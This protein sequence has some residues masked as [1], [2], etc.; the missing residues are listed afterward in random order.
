[1]ATPDLTPAFLAVSRAKLL[2]EYLPRLRA[3]IEPLTDE[4]VWWRPNDASNSIGNLLLHL[5]GNVRQWLVVSFNRQADT[6]QRPAEFAQRDRIP[7]RAL[8]DRL[9]ATLDEAAATLS[10]LTAD[11]LAAAMQIQGYSTTGLTAVYHVVE[12]FGLHYGQIVYIAK[13]LQARDLGFYKELNATGR[14]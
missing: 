5:N 10:R 1:M 12:H 14:A 2:D 3:T 8:L 6:R 11:D 4:Q 9:A 7:T 13:M